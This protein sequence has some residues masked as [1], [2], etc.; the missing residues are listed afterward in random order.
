[1][2]KLFFKEKKILFIPLFGLLITSVDK[3]NINYAAV[4]TLITNFMMI[5]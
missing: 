5:S 4:V 2:E 3:E 1:M